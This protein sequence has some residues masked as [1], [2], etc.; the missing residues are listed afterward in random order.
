MKPYTLAS[1]R[2]AAPTGCPYIAPSLV[3]LWFRWGKVRPSGLLMTGMEVPEYRDTP[4][5]V[6]DNGEWHQVLLSALKTNA[7]RHRVAGRRWNPH[8]AEN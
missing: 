1:E 6:F 7:A 8:E 3:D 5:Q 2:A 4:V